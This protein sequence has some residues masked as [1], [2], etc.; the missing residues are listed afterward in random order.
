MTDHTDLVPGGRAV[1][2]ALVAAGV[3]HAFCVPGESFL[4]L[5]D[6][7]YD[8]PRIRVVATRHE[9]GAS[10]MAEAYG[11][12]TRRPAACMG[13]RMV[14]GGNLA[15]G[16]HTAMQDS[17]P[18]IALLG[19]VSTEARYR[20]AFQEAQLEAV[21]G[22]T[23]KWA[24]EPPRADRLGE[25]TARAG[26][27]AVSGRPGPV[28]VS[29]REDLLDEQVARPRLQP[30]RP[31]SPGPDPRAVAD[32]LRLLRGAR[33][34]LMLLGGG[35]LASGAS[36]LCVQFADMEQV[37]VIAMWRRPDSFP[38]DN[39]LYLGHA[40]VGAAPCVPRR[41]L[42]ADVILALG[43]R[44]SENAT[45]GYTVPAP[46]T[47]LIHV[48]LLP[49]QL[50]GHRQA[51][52]ACVSD[53][54]LF[55]EALLAAA[56]AEP[57]ERGVREGRGDQNEVDRA[58]WEAET[59]PGRGQAHAGYVDQ[60]V[61][62][63]HLRRLLPRDAVTTT[64][65]GNFGGWPARYLRWQETGTFLGPTSGAMGYAIPAAIA[66]K[67]AYPQRK[68]VAFVGDGGFLMTGAEI[69]TAVRIGTPF[70]AVVYDNGQYGTIVMHQRRDHPGRAV[71][72]SLGSVDV[73]GYARALGGVGFTLRDD[74]EFPAALDEALAADRPAVIHLRVDPDQISVGTDA[75]TASV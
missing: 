25:L 72:T 1:V 43:T 47:R 61:V 6:A 35:V 14:G 40:G 5:L 15:I 8:E 49:E 41:M 46:T 62:A 18:L 26:R 53:A 17:T 21:F 44:L 38:N 30:I 48:D 50:G 13:T 70:V 39:P 28:V 23:V 11:K 42:D 52:V 65:A 58:R 29:L 59:L 66:A 12:L 10:F 67:L 73:A 63:A 56:T 45:H 19:Q 69:E 22:P 60:Q 7:L 36:D 20:E 54:R 37:P 68:A 3:D 55:M 4:G 24:V 27:I 57:I 32:A 51:E 9:G 31:V 16:I 2:D 74:R 71:A 34:P 75:K 33:R 64:D